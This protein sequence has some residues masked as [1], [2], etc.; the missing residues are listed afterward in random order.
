MIN[1]SME[2]IKDV[3]SK[4][5]DMYDL[6]LNNNKYFMAIHSLQYIKNIPH[7]MFFIKQ[8]CEEEVNE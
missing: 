2:E 5:K 4:N 6:Y 8:L 1:I 7:L 3:F